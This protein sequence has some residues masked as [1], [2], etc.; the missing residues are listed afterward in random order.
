MSSRGTGCP[1][2]RYAEALFTGALPESASSSRLPATSC[3]YVTD[4]SGASVTRTVPRTTVSC[5]TGAP[6]RSAA[7]ASNAWRASAAALRKAGTPWMMPLL[8]PVPR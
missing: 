6:S 4:R 5:S 3:A 2:R 8:E 1:T 7:M